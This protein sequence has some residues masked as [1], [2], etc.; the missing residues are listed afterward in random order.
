[1]R[2]QKTRDSS[3]PPLESEIC[4]RVREI[5]KRLKWSQPDFAK[6]LGIS[7]EKLASYEYGRAPV[8]IEVAL[9]IG[10][11]FNINQRWLATGKE[12]REPYFE[13]DSS[14]VEAIPVRTLFSE[15]YKLHFEE[16]VEWR[17]EDITKLL[18]TSITSL[19]P[20]DERLYSFSPMG[21]PAKDALKHW[22][23]RIVMFDVE[24]LPESLL[25]GYFSTIVGAAKKF[26]K[27]HEAEMESYRTSEKQKR[28]RNDS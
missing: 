13:V 1:M 9:R 23:S 28:I 10:M 19:D 12:P 6:E 11:Q 21:M 24:Q 8:R 14:V 17:F 5:R 16:L 3:L 22:I 25:D 7:R 15:A 27:T 4:A 26:R 20:E 18:G 2:N